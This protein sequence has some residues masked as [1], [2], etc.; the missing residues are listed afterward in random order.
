MDVTDLGHGFFDESLLDRIASTRNFVLILAPH[1]L[2]KLHEEGDWLHREIRQAIASGCNVVPI[3]LPGFRFPK[4]LPEDIRALPRYQCVEYSHLFFDAMMERLVGMLDLPVGQRAAADAGRTADTKSRS[5][6]RRWV[7][8]AAAALIV[9]GIA[10]F[11]TVR[12][13][14][15]QSTNA[16][17]LKAV[18]ALRQDFRQAGS[19]APAV[20]AQYFAASWQDVDAILQLD[21]NNGTALY[22]SG[23]LRRHSNRALFTENSCPIADGLKAQKGEL[24]HFEADFYR[25]LDIEASLADSDKGGAISSGICYSRPSGYCPQRTAWIDHLLANDL[26]QEALVSD[27]PVAQTNA[28]ERAL[29]L[30]QSAA[31]L[32]QD[33][34]HNPGFTQCETT[35]T[36]IRM[37]QARLRPHGG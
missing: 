30:E 1:A 7:W 4:G 12:Y 28:L 25:Y 17:V 18:G 26:Y 23:E 16:K 32:Y 8:L 21:P 2:D 22:Y 11:F 3:T 15:A 24:D 10:A 36:L 5:G 14:Q 27:D 19:D 9:A 35:E 33:Q 29:K 34:N 31:Q 13:K 6:R 20:R 37:I